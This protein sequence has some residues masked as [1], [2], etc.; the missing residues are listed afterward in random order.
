LRAIP[1]APGVAKHS[2][3]AVRG[4]GPP[5]ED[6]DGVVSFASA[7]LPRMESTRIVRSEHPTQSDPNTADEARRI[8]LFHLDEIC[9]RTLR[10]ASVPIARHATAEAEDTP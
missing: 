9:G 3:I 7:F 4:N 10:C 1:L 8:L 5:E 6:D 2:I